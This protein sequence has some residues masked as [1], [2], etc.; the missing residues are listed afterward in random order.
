[1]AI[2]LLFLSLL[3]L[4]L[5]KEAHSS[6]EGDVPLDT[7]DLVYLVQ[8]LEKGVTFD[9]AI[10][11]TTLLREEDGVL[12]NFVKGDATLREE[13]DE[14]MLVNVVKGVVVEGG[15]NN[16]TSGSE[17]EDEEEVEVVLPRDLDG[18]EDDISEGISEGVEESLRLF[19]NVTGKTKNKW[20]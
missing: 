8:Q 7:R 11:G 15:N 4:L 19:Y 10:N 13:D 1:M 6:E 20:E 3:L 9:E 14:G 5:T 17:E 2:K 12:V 16:G 18:L